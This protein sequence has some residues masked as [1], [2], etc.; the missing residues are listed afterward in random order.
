M[1]H[2]LTLALLVAS[3]ASA[4]AKLRITALDAV[5]TVGQPVELRAKFEGGVS[6]HRPD[7]RDTSVTFT[8][9]ETGL[10]M[11]A[12]TNWDGVASTQIK[13]QVPGVYR[14]R[15]T[16]DGRRGVSAES[17]VWV[18]DP[19]RPVVVIDIDGTLSTMGEL[20]VPF[21]GGRA[22]SFPGAPDVV[23]DLAK[24]HQ[25]VY[26]TARDDGLDR[27]T[28]RFLD[29]HDYP[30]GP[31]IYNDWGVW[32]RSERAQLSSKN[33]GTFK[34]GVLQALRSRGVNLVLGIGNSETD[35]FAYE[36]AELPSMIITEEIGHGPSFR[37]RDYRTEL[38]PKLEEL[39]F[40][41][42]SAGIVEAV[43]QQ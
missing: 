21:A 32:R 17:R 42:A 35:A 14:F 1:K 15:V 20:K 23:R 41:P 11:N 43:E 4:E 16:M 29:R 6:V 8:Q 18:L 27:V 34:L 38:R 30:D 25:V 7:K 26:L 36:Q 19:A 5:T 40:L 2:A 3:A 12:R 24:T 37:F 10:Q 28:R 22:A 33:H 13:A 9:V 39:G 31:V